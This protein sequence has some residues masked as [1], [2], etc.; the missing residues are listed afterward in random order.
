MKSY[1]NSYNMK[2]IFFFQLKLLEVR[3]DRWKLLPRTINWSSMKNSWRKL[4]RSKKVLRKNC[5]KG[6][7]TFFT[8][9]S[10]TRLS[11]ARELE[12]TR[13][14]VV[15]RECSCSYLPCGV[16][17]TLAFHGKVEIPWKRHRSSA[18]RVDFVLTAGKAAITFPQRISK[19]SND[20]WYHF[21]L[22]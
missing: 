11:L 18:K 6:C 12:R 8:R 20:P 1:E 17:E 16:D 2:S 10:S 14:R 3:K 22:K 9:L 5:R 13:A 4:Y 7:D 15:F 19:S 21:E